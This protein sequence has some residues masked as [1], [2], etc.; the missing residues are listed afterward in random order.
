MATY[1][2]NQGS[3]GSKTRITPDSG[4]KF[5]G[6][7][8]GSPRGYCDYDQD[9]FVV[10]ITHPWADDTD[11]A[12]IMAFYTTYKTD[13]NTVATDEG[14]FEGYFMGR[15]QVT[16]KDGGYFVIV[17]RLFCTESEEA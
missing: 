12:A 1:P 13:L 3:I 15:P 14:D 4:I 5:V 10:E 8:T 11:R 6:M 17:S 16:E 7:E 2:V 9:A